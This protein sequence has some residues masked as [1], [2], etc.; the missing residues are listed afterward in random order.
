MA[1]EQQQRTVR[2]MARALGRAGLSGAFG[3]CSLRLDATHFL[4]CA[5]RPMGLI[6]PGERGTV[7]KVEGPLPEGVFGEVRL[8]QQVYRRRP[9]VQAVCRF[10]SPH[11]L[12]LS[13]MGMAPVARHGF[14]AYFH[15]QVP[16]F[17]N[18]K[19]VRDDQTAADVATLMGTAP[20]IVVNVNG[21]VTAGTSAPQALALAWLLEEAARVELAVV[22]SGMAQTGPRLDAVTARARAT[23][24]E[25]R[26]AGRLWEYLCDGDPE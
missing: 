26:T 12:A 10:T 2:Q 9:E 25:G 22:A 15:P 11:V 14:G 8:H 16:F 3:H 23:W 6:R 4:V 18:A 7:A 5:S 24:D 17:P 20:A 21:A 19:L 1:T 13:A